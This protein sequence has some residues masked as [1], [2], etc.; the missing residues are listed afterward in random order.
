ML[1]VQLNV[2]ALAAEMTYF[3]RQAEAFE[4]QRPGDVVVSELRSAL[5]EFDASLPLLRLLAAPDLRNRHW[6]AIFALLGVD[7]VRPRHWHLTLHCRIFC[8]SILSQVQHLV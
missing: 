5:A 6:A 7:E 4:A 8:P 2:E 1:Q 3:W